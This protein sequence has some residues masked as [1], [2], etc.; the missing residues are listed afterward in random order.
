VLEAFEHE[1]ESILAELAGSMLAEG[2]PSTS[3]GEDPRLHSAQDDSTDMEPD[4]DPP[5]AVLMRELAQEM[6]GLM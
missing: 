1:E 5:A 4:V 3:T 6:D 2:P